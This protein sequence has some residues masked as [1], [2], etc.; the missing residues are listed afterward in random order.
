MLAGATALLRAAAAGCVK[1]VVY[2]LGARASIDTANEENITPLIRAAQESY[3]HM[4]GEH[5]V[6]AEGEYMA[7]VETLVE[8]RADVNAR[9]LSGL[10][11][12]H[13]ATL[14][15]NPC[16]VG[17]LLQGRADPDSTTAKGDVPLMLAVEQNNQGIVQVLLEQRACVDRVNNAGNKKNYV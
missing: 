3:I 16:A 14:S 6:E 12:L 17:A 4:D 10:G 7:V 1:S 8:H 9:D 5:S 2:L 13:H 15:E 11:P